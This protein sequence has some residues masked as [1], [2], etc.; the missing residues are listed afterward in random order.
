MSEERVRT[1]RVACRNFSLYSRSD[2]SGSEYRARRAAITFRNNIAPTDHYPAKS[3][4]PRANWF[5]VREERKGKER[6]QCLDT[7][8]R[9]LS[10]RH[11]KILAVES[12]PEIPTYGTY[13]ETGWTGARVEEI[14]GREGEANKDPTLRCNDV[15][16]FRG[17]RESR[18]EE[19]KNL[20]FLTRA[21]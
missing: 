11:A 16:P 14:K 9:N 8:A 19:K 20:H 2:A 5:R 1:W 10:P 3:P 6:N 4:A 12:T 21:S 13:V 18:R 7:I 17:T 15:L